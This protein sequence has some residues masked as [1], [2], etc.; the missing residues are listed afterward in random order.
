MKQA[1]Q[2]KRERK[3]LEI[4][5][6]GSGERHTESV[7]SGLASH[8]GMNFSFIYSFKNYFAAPAICQLNDNSEGRMRKINNHTSKYKSMTLKKDKQGMLL[9]NL[10]TFT[11]GCIM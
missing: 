10:G 1:L 9:G 2:S 5:R 7:A 3:H 11:Q 4:K 8:V 6:G